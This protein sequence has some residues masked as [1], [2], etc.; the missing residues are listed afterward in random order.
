[1]QLASS[2]ARV[3]VGFVSSGGVGSVVLHETTVI[4]NNKEVR[5]VIF[6]LII[7]L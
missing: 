5:I 2:M 3:S 6:I 1:V 7:V 4:N